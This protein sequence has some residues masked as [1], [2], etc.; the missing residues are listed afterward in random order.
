MHVR[1]PCCNGGGSAVGFAVVGVAVV[2]V[3]AV[4][5]D[6]GDVEVLGFALTS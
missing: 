4:V 2:G 3:A 5:E 6:D 1:P